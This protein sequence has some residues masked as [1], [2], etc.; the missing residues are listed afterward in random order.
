M[1]KWGGAISFPV[2][3]SLHLPS[4]PPLKRGSGGVTP[5][6]LFGFYCVVMSFRAFWSSKGVV[7]RNCCKF[8]WRA[9]FLLSSLPLPLVSSFLPSLASVLLL[10]TTQRDIVK[11]TEQ[12]NNTRQYKE[13][14]IDELK[15]PARIQAYASCGTHCLMTL[16]QLNQLTPSNDFFK[17]IYLK[18]PIVNMQTVASTNGGRGVGSTI[19]HGFQKWG[20][21]VWFFL[22][23]NDWFNN[24]KCALIRKLHLAFI[25]TVKKRF[26]V[27][28]ELFDVHQ[29]TIGCSDRQV[30]QTASTLFV[31]VHLSVVVL[32][33]MQRLLSGTVYQLNLLTICHL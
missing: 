5:G 20:V 32:F 14:C 27:H 10:Q 2:I 29:P 17:L 1:K 21:I 33:V 12:V 22:G 16:N 6:K 4:L 23:L 13:A 26:H 24:W 25:N 3:H 7:V 30:K 19:S 15:Q 18:L 8:M 31:P 28:C 9:Y 11:I